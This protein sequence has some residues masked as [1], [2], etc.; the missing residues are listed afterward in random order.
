M[1]ITEMFLRDKC[2]NGRQTHTYTPIH[3]Q[4]HVHKHTDRMR[5]TRWR[6]GVCGEPPLTSIR[7]PPLPTSC[8][9]TKLPHPFPRPNNHRHHQPPPLPPL[10][11]QRSPCH[12]SLSKTLGEQLNQTWHIMALCSDSI[13][14]YFFVNNVSRFNTARAPHG[15]LE[16]PLGSLKG[17]TL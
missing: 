15:A 16:D 13:Y 14:K 9:P 12:I 3:T 17:E 4:T 6:E 7:T 1:K 8:C 11:P 10:I 5:Q 2:G